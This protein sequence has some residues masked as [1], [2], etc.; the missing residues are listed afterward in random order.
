MEDLN[1]WE[2]ALREL[3]RLNMSQQLMPEPYAEGFPTRLP[4]R[5]CDE[6]V[7]KRIMLTEGTNLEAVKDN[8]V[9]WIDIEYK[10]EWE[11]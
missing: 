3:R 9:D 2:R 8:D 5:Y 7:I 10:S 4:L 1:Y 6:A 11:E